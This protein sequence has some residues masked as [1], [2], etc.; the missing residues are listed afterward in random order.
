MVSIHWKVPLSLNKLIVF[1]TVYYYK[2]YIEIL[3]IN[4]KVTRIQADAL[5]V[6]KFKLKIR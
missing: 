6:E 3:L 4:N 5:I 1:N 2:K